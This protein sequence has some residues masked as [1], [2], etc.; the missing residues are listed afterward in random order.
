MCTQP[1][2]KAE[3][4]TEAFYHIE[5]FQCCFSAALNI[6]YRLIPPCIEKSPWPDMRFADMT[7]C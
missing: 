7:E 3:D 4:S 1:G 5:F 2:K 6:S